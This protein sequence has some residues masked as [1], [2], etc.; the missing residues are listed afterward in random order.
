MSLAPATAHRPMGPRANTT[1]ASPMRT[2]PD[3]APLKPVEAM[4]ARS[5][6]CSSDDAVGDGREVRLGRRHEQ[7]LGLSAVDRVAEAPAAERLV[8]PAVAALAQVS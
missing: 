4:S 6:T 5:T 3:S 8:A 7:V 1:T 2:P